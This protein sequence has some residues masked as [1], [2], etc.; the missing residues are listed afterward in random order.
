MLAQSLLPILLAT[1]TLAATLHRGRNCHCPIPTKA[2]DLPS[3]L[4]LPSS[5]PSYVAMGVGV[6]NYQCLSGNYS[7][8]GAD[9]ELYDISCIW[10]T[11]EFESIQDEAFEI[12]SKYSGSDP[13][14][15]SVRHDI[16]RTWHIE[17]IG[18]HHFIEENHTLFPEFN[19]TSA[20]V[21]DNFVVANKTADSPAPRNSSENIDWLE[22]KKANVPNPGQLANEVFRVFTR[23]GQPPHSC[24]DGSS[25]ISVKYTAQYLFFL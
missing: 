19:F 22:L 8:I 12:W 7:S 13:F 9:A 16:E 23:G 2:L 5:A 20:G 11:Q 4:S 17:V 3:P 15:E 6:Q 1:S 14:E 10:E 21:T 24:Q 18:Q 25:N